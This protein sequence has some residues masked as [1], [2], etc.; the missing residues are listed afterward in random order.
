MAVSSSS[1]KMNQSQFE[2]PWATLYSQHW[3]IRKYSSLPPA[4]EA[5]PVRNARFK[6]EK[7][8]VTCYQPKKD[9]LIVEKP[10]KTGDLLAK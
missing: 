5:A 7:G 4:E 9:T 6:Y 8:V 2:H 3:P 10:V 1:I